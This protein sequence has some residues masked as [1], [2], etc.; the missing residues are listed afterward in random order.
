MSKR[1]HDVKKFIIK[2]KTR[3]DVKTFVITSKMCHEVKNMSWCKNICHEVKTCHDVKKFVMTSKTPFHDILFPKKLFMEKVKNT[4]WQHK[5]RHD[6]WSKVVHDI[7]KCV[8]SSKVP[9]SILM[10]W[11]LPITGMWWARYLPS[12]LAL[13]RVWAFW[14]TWFK[15]KGWLFHGNS[16]IFM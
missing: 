13:L 10:G 14:N 5:V 9:F 3:H 1:R 7:T 16:E 6:V 12:L 15:I 4:S 11:T 8:M 2:S